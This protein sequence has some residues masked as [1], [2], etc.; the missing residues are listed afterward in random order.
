MT[1][2]TRIDPA[3]LSDSHRRLR[4]NVR[5]FLMLA[6]RDELVKERAISDPA[7]AK[8]VDELIAELD[9]AGVTSGADLP[10]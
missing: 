7:R 1:T 9:A 10:L 5:N 4:S 3:T 2:A 8:F 6:A